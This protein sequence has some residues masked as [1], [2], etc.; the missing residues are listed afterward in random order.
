MNEGIDVRGGEG[1]GERRFLPTEAG[2]VPLMD[3]E[4]DVTSS[5]SE[6]SESDSGT[7]DDAEPDE[8]MV[9]TTAVQMALLA[10]ARS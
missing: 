1:E 4:V 3:A 6:D 8:G 9:L 5:S 7:E 10:L 2:F